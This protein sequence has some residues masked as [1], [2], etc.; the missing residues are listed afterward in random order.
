MIGGVVK[1][2]AVEA[3]GEL[4]VPG[5]SMGMTKAHGTARFWGSRAFD[6]NF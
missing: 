6:Q 5:D 2:G 3:A 1:G 4:T